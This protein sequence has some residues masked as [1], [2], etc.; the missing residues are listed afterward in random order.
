MSLEKKGNLDTDVHTG[1]KSHEDEGPDQ[2]D[3][4][5]SRGTPEIA[6]NH[7]GERHGTDSLP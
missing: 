6:V 4:S 5:P 7:L 2:G 3:V 1:R